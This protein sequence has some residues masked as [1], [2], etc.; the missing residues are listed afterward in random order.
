MRRYT[1]YLVE[2][3]LLLVSLVVL[4]APLAHAITTT[5]LNLSDTGSQANIASY[6]SASRGARYI[7]FES[8]ANYLVS[9]DTNAKTDMFVRDTVI[10]ATTR[11][12]VSSSGIEGNNNSGGS[13]GYVT[14]NGRYSL[15]KSS[16]S[17]LDTIPTLPPSAVYRSGIYLH[18]AKTGSTT[19]IATAYDGG[20]QSAY[21]EPGSVSEDG[22]FV[23]YDIMKSTVSGNW[24]T[25]V[26]D[27]KSNTDTEISTAADGT[28]S[29]TNDSNAYAKTSCDGRISVFQSSAN[30]L[31]PNDVNGYRDIFMVDS[32]NGHTIK[33]ITISGNGNSTDP[34]ISCDGNFVTF[35]SSASNLVTG[36]TNGAGDG[37][38]YDVTNG[39][40]ER[41]TVGTGG[42]QFSQ[43]GALY[44][45]T[46]TMS[47]DSNYVTFS[48]YD[49]TAAVDYIYVRD[50]LNNMTTM[51]SKS[52]SGTAAN[53]SSSYP[54]L[55]YDGKTVIF[56][57]SAD[58][59]GITN[60]AHYTYLY[61]V[62]A[63]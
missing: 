1:K 19:I 38:I 27:M 31:V 35:N 12:S 4:L 3:A 5:G 58:N 30:N 11:I 55:S 52:S 39:T 41:V 51:V 17:N 32:M 46:A 44:P 25:Y 45:P 16:A 56:L 60:T 21:V 14:A 62:T 29:G 63:F 47:A 34:A 43:G 2:S 20:G 8:S 9:G 57:T 7:I 61:K 49:T 24:H 15:F 13:L 6:Y 33:D 10:G 48:A 28:T 40:I 59:L 22:R 26:K 54:V 23:Y 37:F 18:D 53:R 42:S 36:D 50:R